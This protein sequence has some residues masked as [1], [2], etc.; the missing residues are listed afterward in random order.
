MKDPKSAPGER[1]APLYPEYGSSREKHSPPEHRGERK[2]SDEV[3][4]A[5]EGE[6]V[7][8]ARNPVLHGAQDRER[9]NAKEQAGS[10]ERPAHR[11]PALRE[12]PLQ[13][14]AEAFQPSVYAQTLTDH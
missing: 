3:Q 9:P 8:V 11:A 10:Y 2:R 14:V 4:R 7:V 13:S 5:L 6:E 12:A 1:Q